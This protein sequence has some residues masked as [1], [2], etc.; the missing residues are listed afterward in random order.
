MGLPV[1]QLG[2]NERIVIET[3]EHW[4]HLLGAMVICL[5]ALAGVVI[6]QLIAPAEGFWAWLA[7]A[8]WVAFAV[9]VLIFGVWPWLKWLNRT[10]TLTNER[11]VTREGV[12]RRQGRDIPLDRINDTAYDQGILDRMVKCGTL[13]VSAASEQGTVVLRDIPNVHEFVRTMN[14]LVKEARGEVPA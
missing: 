10:S 13:K 3:R 12:I 2:P 1:S 5:L 6:I 7:T 8:G 4:K 11:L 14:V 9:V